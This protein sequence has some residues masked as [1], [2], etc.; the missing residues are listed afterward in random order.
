MQLDLWYVI[1]NGA[2][3]FSFPDGRMETLCMGN[4]F[5]ISPSLDKQYMNGEVRTKGDDCQVKKALMTRSSIL[6]LFKLEKQIITKTQIAF[7]DFVVF[8][9]GT[10][11]TFI[12]TAWFLYCPHYFLSLYREEQTDEGLCEPYAVM[13]NSLEGRPASNIAADLL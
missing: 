2:V 7:A 3:E 4:S 10:C 12:Q 5:G 13:I 1:L 9:A 8:S 6:F 11:V